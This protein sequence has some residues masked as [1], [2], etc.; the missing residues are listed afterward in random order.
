ME[1]LHALLPLGIYEHESSTLW[2][3]LYSEEAQMTNGSG[4]IA[5]FLGS[6]VSDLKLGLRSAAGGADL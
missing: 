2:T 4:S 1:M 6:N 5:K 3:E